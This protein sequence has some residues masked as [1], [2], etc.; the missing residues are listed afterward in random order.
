MIWSHLLDGDIC[1]R[2]K[3]NEIRMCPHLILCRVHFGAGNSSEKGELE[4]KCEYLGLVQMVQMVVQAPVPP[5]IAII[6][7]PSAK[8]PPPPHTKPKKKIFR[9]KI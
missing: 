7:L 3:L 2:L 4:Q 6:V 9:A 8:S 5:L 1:E